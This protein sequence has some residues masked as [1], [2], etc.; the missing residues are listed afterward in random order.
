MVSMDIP[1]SQD[2]HDDGLIQL[3]YNELYKSKKINYLDC[4]ESLFLYRLSERID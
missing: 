1:Y 2:Y 3:V 4:P